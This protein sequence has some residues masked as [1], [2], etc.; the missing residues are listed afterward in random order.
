MRTR[1][2]GSFPPASAARPGEAIV[3]R[4]GKQNGWI[5][6][7]RGCQAT[8]PG[9]PS[10]PV[11]DG[12]QNAPKGSAEIEPAALLM[13]H[14][15]RRINAADNTR[16]GFDDRQLGAAL[17]SLGLGTAE[18][19]AKA[20]RRTLMPSTHAAPSGASSRPV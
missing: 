5:K 11:L 6:S 2:G 9:S 18:A 15:S 16:H 20:E 19:A 4:L 8:T 14:F 13:A 1:F 12:W 17:R 7:F 10:L 3:D